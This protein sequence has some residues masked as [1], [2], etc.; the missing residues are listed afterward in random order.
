MKRLITTTLLSAAFALGVNAQDA[1]ATIHADKGTQKI[2][3]EIYGQ[4]AEHLGT[5]IYGGL[6]V[7]ENS[8][9]PNTKGYRNDVFQAL[10]D[11]HV[12]VLRWPGGCFADD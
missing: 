6:W 5:C 1:T 7:G 10:K 9:I 3:K 2:N 4:F 11:L 12:P 8:P